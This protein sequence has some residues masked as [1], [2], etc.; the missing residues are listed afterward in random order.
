MI[1]CFCLSAEQT[2]ARTIEDTILSKE[3]FVPEAT[4]KHASSCVRGRWL[5]RVASRA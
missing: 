4:Q 2:V 1:R 5:S 3:I